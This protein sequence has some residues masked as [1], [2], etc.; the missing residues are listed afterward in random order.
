MNVLAELPLKNCRLSTK[1]VAARFFG[2][3]E[4][5]LSENVGVA[6]LRRFWTHFDHP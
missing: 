2:P 5:I 1:F 6:G 3:S 4:T